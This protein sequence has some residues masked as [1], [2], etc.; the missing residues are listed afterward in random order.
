MPTDAGHR[1]YVKGRHLS[2]QRGKRNT[3]PGTSLIQ[4]EGVNNTE[5]A[6]FYCGKKVAF[7]YRASKEVRGSKI[8]VIWG[9]IARPH[10]NS[11]VVRAR[12]RQNLPPKSF[13][14]S[15]RIMLYPSSV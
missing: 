1:L 6:N 2:Y 3:T 4:I 8:R 10:G 5:A 12:F 7:V 11:G 15:V 13:G 9:K 14:A